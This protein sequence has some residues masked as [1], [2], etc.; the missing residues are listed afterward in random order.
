[1]QPRGLHTYTRRLA[2]T[3]SA[4]QAP[5]TPRCGNFPTRPHGDI[6]AARA[7]APPQASQSPSLAR[8]RRARG[9]RGRS[10][11]RERRLAV[12]SAAGA[13]V[14]TRVLSTAWTFRQPVE[15]LSEFCYRATGI[16]CRP[17]YHIRSTCRRH[18]PKSGRQALRLGR[19]FA[20]SRVRLC[21]FAVFG[22]RPPGFCLRATAPRLCVHPMPRHSATKPQGL[23]QACLRASSFGGSRTYSSRRRAP[24]SRAAAAAP[25]SR[26]RGTSAREARRRAARPRP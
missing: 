20:G 22:A 8:N 24:P 15:H 12:Q 9:E 23:C 10:S 16:A 18:N 1:M 4:E 2:H 21:V 6:R 14:T 19:F 7:G 25:R 17:P 11:R 5:R 13:H 26:P 3:R